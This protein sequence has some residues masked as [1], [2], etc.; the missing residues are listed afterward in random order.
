[1]IIMHREKNKSRGMALLNILGDLSYHFKYKKKGNKITKKL[2][3]LSE[4]Y[5]NI[6]IF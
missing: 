4:I 6:L 2:L 5:L 1:M 3:L